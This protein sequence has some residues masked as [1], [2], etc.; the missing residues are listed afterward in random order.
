[1]TPKRRAI[2]LSWFFRFDFTHFSHNYD[3]YSMFRDVSEYSMFLVLLTPACDQS[4]S[5]ILY[6]LELS[7]DVLKDILQKRIAVVEFGGYK[8]VKYDLGKC[9]AVEKKTDLQTELT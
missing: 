8:Y 6:R 2:N 9:Y 4:S 7:N 5:R 3:T 1:M